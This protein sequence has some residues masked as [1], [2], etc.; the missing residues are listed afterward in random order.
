MLMLWLGSLLCQ[1]ESTSIPRSCFSCLRWSFTDFFRRIVFPSLQL[2]WRVTQDLSN[3][4]LHFSFAE[5][6]SKPHC[7]CCT[8]SWKTHTCPLRPPQVRRESARTPLKMSYF[9]TIFPHDLQAD[10]FLPDASW[11]NLSCTEQEA[12][13]WLHQ[14]AFSTG[15]FKANMML[16]QWD[17]SASTSWGNC[18]L[19]G[20]FH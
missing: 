13:S 4:C 12:T 3:C 5:V 17:G 7:V 8:N 20:I 16:P 6:M 1:T 14:A 18:R 15:A 10:F 11:K 9:F 2:W 19:W